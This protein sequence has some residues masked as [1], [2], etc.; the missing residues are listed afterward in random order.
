MCIATA[1][2]GPQCSGINKEIY[3]LIKSYFYSEVP[4]DRID[5]EK[6]PNR[7]VE[8]VFRE[9]IELGEPDKQQRVTLIWGAVGSGLL[10]CMG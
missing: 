9:P 6:Y 4:L 10:N 3:F 2:M 7:T 1:G 5:T 8:F